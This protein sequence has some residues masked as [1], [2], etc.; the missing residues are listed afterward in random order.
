MLTHLVRR[1]LLFIPVLVLVSALIFVLVRVLPGDVAV[2][3][4][5]GPEGSSGVSQEALA[6]VRADLGLDRPLHVQYLAWIGDVLRLN[7]GN[8]FISRESIVSEIGRRLP[9]TA[10]FAVLTLL[11][12]LLIAIPVGIISAI[13]QSTWVDY[14]V[15]V[16]SIAG[17]T[18]PTFW[19]GSL[20]ILVLMV[21][22]D[23]TPPLGYVT[24]LQD[25]WTNLQQMVFPAL[26]MG[27]FYS[28][29]V[30]RMT[31]STMLEVLR[32]EYIRTA[33]AKGLRERV[34]VIRHALRNAILPVVTI[35]GFQFGHLLGGSV[36]LETLFALPG[37]GS[38]LIDAIQGRDYVVVQ[39]FILLMAVWFLLTN[40]FVD[41]L[42][43]WLDPRVRYT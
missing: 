37:L 32:Q 15:R 39:T 40:L 31:R 8:S 4:L 10:E 26:A 14:L 20:I 12:S 22:F 3:I 2:L 6:R 34:V 24:P 42:Y 38:G 1:L 25:P 27:Y 33:W 21:Y 5:A 35:S 36:I 23:W 18:A 9:V 17:L 29:V 43:A 19:T 30:S 11:I 16:V 28:A 7:L 41:L 13:R